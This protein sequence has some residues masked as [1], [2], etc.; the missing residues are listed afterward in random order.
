MLG[1]QCFL[2]SIVTSLQWAILEKKHGGGGVDWGCGISRGIEEKGSRIS[3]G[4]I[5]KSDMEFPGRV[6]SKENMW[7]LFP[8][9]LGMV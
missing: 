4:Y 7:N 1:F 3:K 8:G 6:W 5:I 2:L 9:F